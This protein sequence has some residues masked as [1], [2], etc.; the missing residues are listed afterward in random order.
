[1]NDITFIP[2]YSLKPNSLTVFER[3]DGNF[4]SEKQI[5]SFA[6]LLD[7]EN[8]YNELSTHSR[9]RL[10]NSIEFLLYISENREITGKQF[11][12]KKLSTEIEKVQGRKF[13]N[14]VKYK[15]TF[16]T[17]TLSAKQV[18]TD[19]VIKS[20]LL[21]QFLTTARKKWDMRYYI[22]K[23]EKQENGNIHFHILTNQYIKYQ[24]IRSVW[25]GI[26]NKKGFHYVDRYSQ[27]MQKY[28]RS[29][30]RLFPNDDR[31]RIKQFS[32]YEKN[33]KINW[34][35]PNSTDIHALYKVKNIGAYMSKYMSKS[36]TK[37]ERVAQ[38]VDFYNKIDEITEMLKA[39]ETQLV[40]HDEYEMTQNELKEEKKEL[41]THLKALRNKGV[42][43]RIWGQSQTLSKLKNYTDISDYYNIPDIEK[44]QKVKEFEHTF[45]VGSSQ[46]VTYKFD[47]RKTPQLKSILD[48]H[49]KNSL[50]I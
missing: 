21:N 11:I 19:E 46:V 12:S 27:N 6:N 49:I 13:S 4:F 32:A 26:Q 42:S 44:A 50:N 33:K 16:V 20:K 30:F 22:W 15:L 25:N 23:A 9:K 45:E 35:N 43:G 10:R 5:D 39:N 37:T 8:K 41:E 28:F 40:F 2:Y 14:S 24:E 34:V 18:H 36:V 7:N 29:G 48:Q 38:M 1:M 17:L 3:P 47:I 31:T